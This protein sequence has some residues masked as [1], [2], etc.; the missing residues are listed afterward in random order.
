L[1]DAPLRR[2]FDPTFLERRPHPAS[3]ADPA[4]T[5]AVESTAPLDRQER[6][7]APAFFL[8]ERPGAGRSSARHRAAC[9]LPSARPGAPRQ[10]GLLAGTRAI[11]NDSILFL[12]PVLAV[13]P[14]NRAGTSG[15]AHRSEVHNV[16]L[17]QHRASRRTLQPV[18]AHSREA[19]SHGWR[20]ALHPPG[21][22]HPLPGRGSRILDRSRP[23]PFDL[24]LGFHRRGIAGEPGRHDS[25]P[26]LAW[27]PAEAPATGFPHAPGQAALPLGAPAPPQGRDF[28]AAFRITA[29]ARGLKC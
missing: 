11:M 27:P 15:Q 23:A 16:H 10:G 1:S 12:C 3:A 13:G 26:T 6:R 4:R 22:L 14:T 9:N 25:A 21:R 5:S 8:V 24:R 7:A 28:I 19:S 20:S 18:P 17:A 29:C 2:G